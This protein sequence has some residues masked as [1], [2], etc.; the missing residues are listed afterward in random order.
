ML[1]QISLE[2][3]SDGVIYNNS[4]LEPLPETI[5]NP[6]YRRIYASLGVNK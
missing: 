3:V 6:V 1:I 5:M 2:F 4:E